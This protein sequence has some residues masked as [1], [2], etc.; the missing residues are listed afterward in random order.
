MRL[1]PTSSLSLKKKQRWAFLC[2]KTD[3]WKTDKF[4][5]FA[6]IIEVILTTCIYAE[7]QCYQQPSPLASHKLSGEFQIF[8]STY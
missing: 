7:V 2:E 3:T 6:F 4:S 8:M 1:P 5:T